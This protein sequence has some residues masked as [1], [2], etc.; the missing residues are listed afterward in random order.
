MNLKMKKTV[1]K[2]INFAVKIADPELIILFGS[3][4]KGTDNASSDID[5]L[6]VSE[7]SSMKRNII[8]LVGNYAR[9]LS[10]RADV[11]VFSR[12][13]FESVCQIPNS[14]A[15]AI[16]KHGKIIWKKT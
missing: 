14:F 7:D 10:L 5:L 8:D 6:I 13:E 15:S 9:E 16:A 1:D 2:I 3:M 4:A 11:L 12:S